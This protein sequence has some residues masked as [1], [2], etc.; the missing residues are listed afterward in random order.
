MS[1][2]DLDSELVYEMES[3][4]KP[5]CFVFFKNL[6]SLQTL[7]G[8]FPSTFWSLKGGEGWSKVSKK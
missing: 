7:V 1:P 6:H 5:D 4:I 8:F 2:V 3:P